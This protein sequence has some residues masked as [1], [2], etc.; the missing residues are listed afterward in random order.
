[1]VSGSSR[2]CVDVCRVIFLIHAFVMNGL[3][4]LIALFTTNTIANSGIQKLSVE[5]FFVS[6]DIIVRCLTAILIF[7][8]PISDAFTLRCCLSRM[9]PSLTFNR[10][11]ITHSR[12]R[13]I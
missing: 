1:M 2:S 7:S 5:S 12:K 3:S 9:Y 13:R 4:N 6:T 11:R 10:T 8:E